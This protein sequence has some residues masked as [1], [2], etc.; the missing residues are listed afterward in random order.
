[1]EKRL[2]TIN[3]LAAKLKYS[4]QALRE[5]T[6]KKEIPYKKIGKRKVAYDPTE[7]MA[8]MQLHRVRTTD[9]LD[10][11]LNNHPNFKNQPK[12]K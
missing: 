1:M 11:Q 3:E 7:I 9:E 5:K 12:G 2:L 8:W 10:L 6:A 4:V